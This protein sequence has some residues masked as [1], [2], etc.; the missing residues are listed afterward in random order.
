[1]YIHIDFS[2]VYLKIYKIDRV[3]VNRYDVLIGT[4]NSI[5]YIRTFYISP[6]YENKLVISV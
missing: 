2:R 3:L 4:I 5:H 1:M 6:V